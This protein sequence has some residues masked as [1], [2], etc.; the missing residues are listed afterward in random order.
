MPPIL[1]LRNV[2]KIY[3]TSNGTFQLDINRLD[4]HAGRSLGI[5]GPSGCGKSTL[6]EL[7]ALISRP[8]HASCF[9]FHTDGGA[10]DLAG[11]W[12]G[13]GQ[14][15]LAAIRRRHFGFVHQTGNLLPFL[16]VRENIL[17]PFC[18][19]RPRDRE[20]TGH[21]LSLVSF[22][23]IEHLLDAPPNA[24]SYGERQRVAIAR[25]LV[26]RPQII[27]A[28]EP[29]SA[30][31]PESGHKA[32]ELL[33]SGAQRYGSA[34]VVVSHDYDLLKDAAIPMI[35]LSRLPEDS[36]GTVRWGVPDHTDEQEACEQVRAA[37]FAGYSLGGD[38]VKRYASYLAWRDFF[39]ERGLSLCGVL[40]FAAALTPILL[41]MGLRYGIVETLSQ[42]LINN[43]ASLS[44]IPYGSKRYTVEELNALGGHP[45]VVFLV[46]RTRML[47]A[48]VSISI[49]NGTS[50]EVD[51]VPSA[52]G[53]PVLAR[54]SLQ[55][56]ADGVVITQQLAR[57][58][59]G[60][61]VG[62]P[63][64]IKIIR[65]NKGI[66][67]SVVCERK[68]LGV[69]PDAADW[70]AQIYV[71]L[72]FAEAIESYRDGMPFHDFGDKEKPFAFGTEEERTYSG[73]RMYV[74]TLDDVV[75]M[76]DFL[77]ER[78]IET[79]TF[80]REI[81]TLQKIRTALLWLT[82]IIGGTAL[83]GMIFSLV[84][85]AA[86][87][88]GRK[89]SVFAQMSLMG[90]YHGSL[91]LF[92]LVQMG[93]CAF[94]AATV[95]L[96]LYKGAAVLFDVACAAW[97]QPGESV[98]SIPSLYVVLLYASSGLIAVMAC[99]SAG[100]RLLQFQPAE[101]LRRNV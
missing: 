59:P 56:T 22:L 95:T 32:M 48:S 70:K 40:A 92:P 47:A 93:L 84:S 34:L 30:L 37:S 54:Y 74:K 83:G 58:L 80:A 38:R 6:L 55:A 60:A 3:R 4:L 7:L 23:R 27:L 26:H 97:L 100:N 36:C 19:L 99:L 21:L 11:L 15:D 9:T 90:F 39:Y 88:V 51:L 53:D 71:P 18:L 94:F 28:D 45:S 46:P 76:R 49:P 24:L 101:V 5:A 75:L 57:A 79:Y 82:A 81:E 91:M 52:P 41:L 13:D 77:M 66:M 78:K 25:A 65:R 63:V 96:V 61:V 31:D 43:P 44:V 14:S 8:D 72:S 67:E 29:T 10:V 85:L 17:L 50:S 12:K 73:F 98:C 62:D 33:A 42:R 16:S 86:S 35:H 64:R 2:R 68:L 69:L 89:S 20:T 87:S 1:Q